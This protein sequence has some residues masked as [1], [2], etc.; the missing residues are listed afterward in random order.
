[1]EINL[2][3]VGRIKESYLVNAMDEY[4]KRIGPI[5]KCN[6]LEMKEFTFDDEKKNLTEEAKLILKSIKDN[7]FVVVLDIAGQQMSSVEFS[8]YISHHYLYNTKTLTFIIGSSN[9]LAPT[10]YERSNFQLSFSKMTFP[11][12]LMRVI[13][14]EQLYRALS[15]INNLK[16]HK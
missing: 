13:F 11:H 14:V 3:V 2:I 6:I 1:M 10:V 8:S 16:Y 4:L 9:G 15:I 5:G 12:Q 7:D